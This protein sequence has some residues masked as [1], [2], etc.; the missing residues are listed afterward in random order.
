MNSLFTLRSEAPPLV[1]RG[2][3]ILGVLVLLLVWWLL[4]LGGTP[5]TRFISPVLLPSPGEVMRG[6]PTLFS[7]RAL[8]ASIAATLKRVFGGFLLA[9][10]VGVP[11]GIIA[12]SYKLFDA[13]TRPLSVF[14]RNVP[15]AVL[16]PL[17][18]L[19]FGI[20]ET[21]KMMFI[22]ISTVPFV[23]FDAARAIG[24]VHDRYVE[25][26][27]TLGASPRQV[28][29]KVLI[30]LAM[31]DIFGSLRSLF[32]LAFGYI[33][34]AELVNAEHGLGYLLMTSQRRGLTEHI[35]AILILIGLLA[36][37]IDRLLFFFQRGLF[38]YRVEND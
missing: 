1:R 16:I 32:G 18:I 13:F 23:F 26:A 14:A 37:G 34:L 8:L 38:P 33:M 3:G 5:E 31:P 11:L 20:D 25:T 9:I 36:Y 19:W 17:T 24:A 35:F 2:A 15:V 12:G 7:E 21:Q 6:I 29:S 30:A 4:T 27:Q 28:I 10:L 22:F